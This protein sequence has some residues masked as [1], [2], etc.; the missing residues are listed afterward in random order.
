MEILLLIL[1]L[2]AILL[3]AVAIMN[4]K[5]VRRDLLDEIERPFPF[6]NE[7]VAK[8]II[9]GGMTLCGPGCNKPSRRSGD[10][11]CMN[12]K[13]CTARKGCSCHL[14][15]RHKNAPP[16][17]PDSWKHEAE[18]AKKIKEDENRRYHC[19]CVK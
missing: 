4:L 10:I 13:D 5:K 17:D 1:A 14:F 12:H 3:S 8:G 16:Y 19:F 2:V 9:V 15:S 18:P 11:W 6:S 7:M